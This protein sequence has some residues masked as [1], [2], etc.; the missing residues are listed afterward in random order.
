MAVATG[1]F[2]P[3]MFGRRPLLIATSTL[4]GACLI[5]VAILTT[6]FPDPS[7][8]VQK[9]SIALIFLWYFGFGVQGP[10]IWI[11]T[12]ESAPTRNREKMLGLATFFGFGVQ[13]IITFVSPYIQDVGYGGLGSKI[14]FIWGAFS[15][16]M[17]AYSFFFVP[18][19][20]GHSLEQLDY[21]FE[22]RT[23][24]RQFSSHH[25]EDSVLAKSCAD[26]HEATEVALAEESEK[27]KSEYA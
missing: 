14:G 5:I 27:E 26:A 4:C 18:E 12:A 9:A 16:I 21:L 22:Q 23:P 20:K 6:A 19:Y 15:I 24:T 25:F 1:Y 11:V 2:L 10:L 17:V 7:E 8:A 13:L 3:D